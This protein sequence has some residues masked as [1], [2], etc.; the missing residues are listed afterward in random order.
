MDGQRRLF[1]L[2]I[3]GAGTNA[4]DAA[5]VALDVESS[6]GIIANKVVQPNPAIRGL[7]A[8]FELDTRGVDLAEIRAVLRKKKGEA[9][10]ETWLYRWTP[11]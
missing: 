4:V 2:D 6:A 3:V 8:S 11:D 7:R 10:S 1:L 5:R 9:A